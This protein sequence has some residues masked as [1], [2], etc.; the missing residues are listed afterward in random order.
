MDHLKQIF[1][2]EC[3]MVCPNSNVLS[4]IIVDLCYGSNKNNTFVWDVMGE[5]IYQNVLKNSNNKLSIPI[6]DENGDI[7]FYGERFAL[8]EKV[9]GGESND[10]AE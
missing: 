5:Q 3:D 1:L 2:Q 6:K 10:C 8:C 9:I 7:E 4:N